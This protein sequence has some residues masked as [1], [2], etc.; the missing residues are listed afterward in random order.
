MFFHYLKNIRKYLVKNG[1]TKKD[2][3]SH[4]N[5]IIIRYHNFPLK[6]NIDKTISKEINTWFIINKHYKYFYVYF[7]KQLLEYFKNKVLYLNEINIK[8]GKTNS[9]ENFNR[10]FKNEFC[11]KGE[12]ENTVYID[13]LI[14]LCRDKNENYEKIN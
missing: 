9:Q 2:N 7:K 1:F 5:C 3:I 8:F 6:Q 12:I 10:V 13:T 4:Y 11:Q 14:N